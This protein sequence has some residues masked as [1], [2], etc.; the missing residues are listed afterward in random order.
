MCQDI[1]INLEILINSKYKNFA[2]KIMYILIT[3]ALYHTWHCSSKAMLPICFYAST[4]TATS[5]LLSV[6]YFKFS[7]IDFQ[8]WSAVV[9]A[10][11][12]TCAVLGSGFKESSSH[13]ECWVKEKKKTRAQL[14]KRNWKKKLLIKKKDKKSDYFTGIH[15]F[16]HELKTSLQLWI[17]PCL[18]Y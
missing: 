16:R 17:K 3:V 9:G 5:I 14:M 8:L 12:T 11:A 13:L 4:S 2:D 18:L 15:I 10:S 7:L 1:L 6:E